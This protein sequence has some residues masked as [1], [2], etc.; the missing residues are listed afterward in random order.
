MARTVNEAFTIFMR[1]FVNLAPERNQKAKDSRDAMFDRI[2]DLNDFFILYRAKHLQFG[3]FARKTKIRPIDDIDLIVCI[4][5]GDLEVVSSYNWNDYKLK[6]TNTNSYLKQYCDP[7]VT[8][9]YSYGS[10]WYLNSNK[11]KNK[12]KSSL[13]NL[14][15]CRKAEL[16]SEGQAVTLQ[17]SSYEWNF[18]IV[19][20]FNCGDEAS[21]TE[22]YLIPNGRGGWAKTNPKIDRD[23]VASIDKRLNGKAREL[24]RLAKYWNRRPTMASI[25]SYMLEAM[26]L[27]FCE[28][29]QNISRIDW[30]FVSLIL[31][32]KNNIY[33]SVPDPKNI[34]GNLNVLSSGQKFSIQQRADKD[35]QRAY[36]AWD[37]EQSNDMEEAINKWKEVLGNDFP[38]YG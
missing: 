32:I 24:V 15:D 36:S 25:P 17:F 14:H 27:D 22:Y 28:Q 13:Q 2:N 11:I 35:Y 19:P 21:G 23:R 5:G 12:F 10:P 33:R 20:A 4:S 26:V 29:Q 34:Q 6:L 1:D 30:A 8:S 7:S 18:D 3:S 16:H 9:F 31:Y 38:S 37:Y